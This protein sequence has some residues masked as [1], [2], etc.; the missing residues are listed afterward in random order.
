MSGFTNNIRTILQLDD[1][2]WKKS[3]TSI[4]KAEKEH[5]SK[6]KNLQRE[7]AEIVQQTTKKI[8]ESQKNITES[9]KEIIKTQ[10][11]I[12]NIINKKVE[13][14][15][16]ATVAETEQSKEKIAEIRQELK[17]TI[18][19]YN[20][21][22]S[23]LKEVKSVQADVHKQ[24]IKAHKENIS[25][26]EKTKTEISKLI[27]FEQNYQEVLKNGIK[28]FE[29]IGRISQASIE[30][31][32]KALLEQKTDYTEIQKLIQSYKTKTI[33]LKNALENNIITEKEYT[34]AIRLRNQELAKTT[35][36]EKFGTQTT[37]IPLNK[38][39]PSINYQTNLVQQQK[40]TLAQIEADK[41][42]E[43]QKYQVISSLLAQKRAEEALENKQKQ[44]SIEKQIAE[45]RK[46]QKAKYETI[47]SLLAQK[48]AEEQLKS[49]QKEQFARD[50]VNTSA[51]NKYNDA[52]SK[53][54]DLEARGIITSKEKEKALA[55]EKLSIDAIDQ[56]TSNL[57]NTT[58][59]Y[60]RWAGTIAGVFYAGQRAW[61]MTLGKGI[62][63]N[64][65]IE[66]N[67]TG[68]AALLGANTSMILSNGKVVNSYEKFQMGLVKSKE[69][70]DN[71][72]VAAKST[73]ATFP[74]LTEIYQ[75][76]IGQT[77][78]FGTSFGK[79]VDDISNNTIKLAQRM[80][81]IGGAI[82]QPMD[83][84]K[85]EIRS[86]V[87]GNVS[88][89]SI[90]STMIFGSPT[91][92]NEAIKK[93]KESGTNGLK[94]MLDS[95]LKA[96]DVL[97]GVK[98]Y[99]KAQLDLQ[100][101]ISQTQGQ[102]AEP[103]FNALKEVFSDIALQI[104][105][106][107]DD[108]TFTKWGEDIVSTGKLIIEYA[109]DVLVAFL[110]W[111]LLPLTFDAVKIAI[112]SLSEASLVAGNSIS[113]FS[114]NAT[115]ATAKTEA[116][117]LAGTRVGIA[118]KGLAASLAPLAA[119]MIAYEGYNWLI[120]DNIKK[121]EQLKGIMTQKID[122]LNKISSTQ[123]V[124]NKLLLEESLI[125]KERDAWKTRVDAA[126]YKSKNNLTDL[127]KEQQ[128]EQARLNVQAEIAKQ[129][130]DSTKQQLSD[131]KGILTT[132][133]TILKK[134]Q[135]INA[136][137][138][139]LVDLAANMSRNA[140]V[141]AD[142][143]TFIKKEE[144]KV[145]TLAKQKKEYTE[146]LVKA[147]KDLAEVKSKYSNKNT[148]KFEDIDEVKKQQEYI[149]NLKEGISTADKAISEERDKAAKKQTKEN[150]TLLKQEEKKAKTLLEINRDFAEQEGIRAEIALIESGMFNDEKLKEQM[151]LLNIARLAKEYELLTN[152]EDKEKVKLELLREGL[153]YE[154]LISIEQQLRGDKSETAQELI[155]LNDQLLGIEKNI[156][157]AK[158][159]AFYSQLA[160]TA[161]KVQDLLLSKQITQAEADTFNKKLQGIAETRVAQD[162]YQKNL[163]AGIKDFDDA[164][165][166]I[167]NQTVTIDVKFEGFNE[168]IKGFASIANGIIDISNANSQVQE[169]EK[170]LAETRKNYPNDVAKIGAEEKKLTKIKSTQ[171]NTTIDGYGDMI[172]AIGNF[173]DEDDHRRERQQK[174]AEA[175]HYIKMAQQLSEMAQSTAFTSLFVAQE[176]AKSTAAGVTA[177]ATAAQ[178]SPW[179]GFATAA[180]MIALLASIGLALGGSSA[181]TS[182]SSD[183]LSSMKANTGAGTVL[184]D[185]EAQSE[186]IV[187]ALSILEDFAEPQYQTLLSMNKYLANISNSIG[188]VTSLLVQSGGFAFG[189]GFTATDSGWKNKV[190]GGTTSVVGLGV[191]AAMGAAA[192]S[193]TMGTIYAAAELFG[194]GATSALVG[195]INAGL[196]AGLSTAAM[197]ALAGTGI[198]I[199]TMLT[200]K[201]LLDGAISK[202]INSIVGGIFGKKKTTQALTDSGIYF[203]DELLK[204]A[205]ESFNGSAYQT[206]TTTTTKKSWFSKSSSSVVNSYFEDLDSETERQFS[207][208]LSGIYNTVLASGDALDA[209]ASTLQTQLDNFVISIGKVSLKDK[210]G[211]EIQTELTS[212]F[213]KISDDVAKATFP[214][215]TP[216]QKVGE[217]LFTTMTRVSTGMEEAE[218]YIK[219]LGTSFQDISYT[220]ILNKQGDV[221]FEALLQ[222]IIKTDEAV[223]GLDNNLV[224]II[225]N[226]D[227]TAEE[228][229]VVY[230][231][232]DDLRNVLKFLKLDTDAVSYA[233]IRGAGSAEALAQGM[234]SYTE[235][236]L[237]DA[238]QLALSTTQLQIEF[239]KL[240]VA[241]PTNKE[242]FTELIESL[243]LSSEAGQELYGRLIILSESF[244]TVADSV[245]ESIDSLESTLKD[246][247][248]TMFDD[249]ISSISN[250][251]DS[252]VGMAESTEA[253]ILGIK[254]GDTGNTQ[255]TIYNKFVEY[256]KLLAK[257]EAAQISG[258]TKTAESS[259]NSLLGMSSDLSQAGYQT[260]IV[261]LLESKLAGFNTSKDILRVNIVDGLGSLINLTE[262]QTN[263]L[264]LAAKD[265]AVTNSELS[266]I[267]GLTESQTTSIKE[268]ASNSNYFSTEDTLSNLE[269]YAAAQLEVLRTSQAEEKEALSAKTFSTGDYLGT[270]EKIDISKLLGVSYD[271]AEP[272]VKSLQGLNN[273]STD[274]AKSQISSLIGYKAGATSYNTSVASQIEKLSSYLG[275]NAS[276]ALTSIS[277]EASAN[278][279][280]QKEAE[281]L[282]KIKAEF[283]AAK[284]QWQTNFANTTALFNQ[285]KNAYL[286]QMAPARGHWSIIEPDW[287]QGKSM[288]TYRGS[289]ANGHYNPESHWQPSLTAYNQI[290][291][292][293]NEKAIKGYAV[294]SPYIEYDQ[295]AQIH[296]GEA[297]IPKT[298][299]E[300][301]QQ[302]DL[303]MGSTNSFTRE[304][305]N[306]KTVLL[307]QSRYFNGI[308]TE[309]KN[310]VRILI[311]S[312]DIQNESLVM[313]E[314][315]EGVI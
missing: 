71:I 153:K 260:E 96:F 33:D 247:S 141:E 61:D 106:M 287:S 89:D 116:L 103:T 230:T 278:L 97:E 105:K 261:G 245:Q 35:G 132:R 192:S 156:T 238:Q 196:S 98:T 200:D 275:T 164:I 201:F 312:R 267:S 295:L 166:N 124:Y 218:Y 294:G 67:T 7:Y 91:Q 310:Q 270:Q 46:Y 188:G 114:K 175:F 165:K 126:N 135:E 265:G 303:M 32:R 144:E 120:G 150:D 145:V 183:S 290:Q 31:T 241:M 277:S 288:W 68:I 298:F 5:A 202:G 302:G 155:T 129:D 77:L 271:T 133:E 69:I 249:F 121:E 2:D 216:F 87:S 12:I 55:K 315:I 154:Q 251:F 21:Q 289:I 229:Y 40:E 122:D 50:F 174:L 63:V 80:S 185:T 189:E 17:E 187:N 199:V 221:G 3:L 227:S 85:E 92:A 231:A 280:A 250:M 146:N 15:K 149:K 38:I 259:Y 300:G 131:T 78:S 299:N 194:T 296:K 157:S 284:A 23:E 258:D 76:A 213:G 125:Q 309:L 264:Q 274:Q 34:K 60:L 206:I 62:E 191:N 281:R 147:E 41:K 283:E 162:E 262:E 179:T 205:I 84:I 268:F 90:I 151:S 49:T 104:N 43:K 36:I 115:L 42:Y 255:E 79:T 282:A 53:L 159:E 65:M 240:N 30:K 101:A 186:S 8:T 273:L 142:L 108:K 220:D 66:D 169:Q 269:A 197:G 195:G 44:E 59:R 193:A 88:T 134:S 307:D 209:S 72:R 263:Q 143:K 293:L 9:D 1:K 74:Q 190:G 81:N 184:G 45:E 16:K 291:S 99:T 57:A 27:S 107:K 102:L 119:V 111:K 266:S 256:N 158:Q 138:K 56:S 26:H 75:Q 137:Q 52:L 118:L 203:A 204:N 13:A 214:L 100:D 93:A 94:D 22:I 47:T 313:L 254:T 83:R 178:S 130:Y 171:F 224:Q 136:T 219:R 123:L 167:Q 173:Y 314:N 113:N 152:I 29:E 272:L 181:K 234:Q 232:L 228:L 257:F 86:M 210:T 170:I 128:A 172:G 311:E 95:Y 217:G 48:R 51:Q 235:G 58:I 276:S 233:S 242:S 286:A 239:N 20:S 243:D 225:E 253:T 117:A 4:T 212:I 176:S 237:T 70:M 161:V 109:D 306:I 14:R 248:Q 54:N 223:Y 160:L 208:V 139:E 24:N 110:G 177:V 25:N 292:L 64:K 82:G 226:L 215:L 168:A 180:A 211:E 163:T 11:E 37:A 222:S 308:I 140:K 246:K 39:A 112:A 207:L 236:F 285:E 182:V 301:L 18:K 6:F 279:V 19:G 198:G 244:A 28:E 252:I 304:L 73:Y 305:S 297:I 127:S 148:I 10:Y